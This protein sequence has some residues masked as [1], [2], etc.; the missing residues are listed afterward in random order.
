MGF[1]KIFFDSP[2]TA[3]KDCEENFFGVSG[4]SKTGDGEILDQDHLGLV[5]TKWL[6]LHFLT[7]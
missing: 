4:V 2:D 5:K 7:I 6:L 3:E 1:F